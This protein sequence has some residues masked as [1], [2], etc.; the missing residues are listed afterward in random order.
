MSNLI[1]FK[2]NCIKSDYPEPAMLKWS[3]EKG[4]EYINHVKDYADK[5]KYWYENFI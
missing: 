1:L 4:F 3:Y 5:T 2:I